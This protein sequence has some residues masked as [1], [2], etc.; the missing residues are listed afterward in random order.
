MIVHRVIVRRI[1][2]TDRAAEAVEGRRPA[3]ASSAP[4]PAR[5]GACGP[6]HHGLVMNELV[7]PSMGTTVRLLADAPLE[8]IRPGSRRSPLG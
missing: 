2:V 7:F 4:A 5:F 3:Q 6:R 8:P 1:V